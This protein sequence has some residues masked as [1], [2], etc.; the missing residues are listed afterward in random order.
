[1]RRC[2]AVFSCASVAGAQDQM[3][4]PAFSERSYG[5]RSGR[6]AHDAILAAQGHIQSGRQ[7]VVD[8]DLE[9]FFGRRMAALC[10]WA[11]LLG[12]GRRESAIFRELSRRLELPGADPH[13]G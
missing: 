8:V 5:F 7:I 4:Q 11:A 13:A 6:L 3:Q 12:Q 10:L 2:M 1:M 9:E